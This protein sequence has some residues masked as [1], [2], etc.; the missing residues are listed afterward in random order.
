ME[1][2][3]NILRMQYNIPILA[4]QKS[5][6]KLEVLPFISDDE[7]KINAKYWTSEGMNGLLIGKD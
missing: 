3:N 4:E 6:K 1:F 7:Q 2:S 5:K